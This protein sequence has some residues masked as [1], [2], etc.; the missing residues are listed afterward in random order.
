[1]GWPA[2]ASDFWEA[3]T[4]KIFTP[5]FRRARQAPI[6]RPMAV[7]TRPPP[8]AMRKLE[9]PLPNG[10]AG[11][12]RS[13]RKK[14]VISMEPPQMAS[15]EATISRAKIRFSERAMPESHEVPPK[16]VAICFWPSKRATFSVSSVWMAPAT[17]KQPGHQPK[18]T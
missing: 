4:F 18:T 11:V 16:G 12:G 14:P 17:S 15:T 6:T 9:V 13:V 10:F 7:P 5:D 2:N 3:V 8:P 1:M